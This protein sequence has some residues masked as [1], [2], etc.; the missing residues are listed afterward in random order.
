M[1]Y[2]ILTLIKTREGS[3]IFVDM[4]ATKIT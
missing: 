2:V 3:E 1:H 4:F